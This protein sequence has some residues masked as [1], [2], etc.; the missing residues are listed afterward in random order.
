MPKGIVFGIGTIDAYQ[1][2][3][4]IEKLRDVLHTL[5]LRTKR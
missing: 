4:A 2:G 3:A 5:R 1:I